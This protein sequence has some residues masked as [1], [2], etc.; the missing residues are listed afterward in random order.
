[1]NPP[2]PFSTV[3]GDFPAHHEPDLEPRGCR[4]CREPAEL[5]RAAPAPHPLPPAAGR[6]QPTQTPAGAAPAVCPL[7]TLLWG[8]AGRRR[9]SPVLL[10]VAGG[11]DDVGVAEVGGGS[12]VSAL[13]LLPVRRAASGVA[14]ALP[15]LL[16][17]R[18]LRTAVAGCRLVP[19][20][21]GGGGPAV[22]RPGNGTNRPLQS[23]GRPRPHR[24]AAP[25]EG[26]RETAHARPPAAT[27]APSRAPTASAARG[28][29]RGCQRRLRSAPV[30]A[31]RGASWGKGTN[32]GP[33]L[34][35]GAL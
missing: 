20:G 32:R 7:P 6:P 25:C 15:G 11:L 2:S 33:A 22:R 14:A 17:H 35:G 8:E 19:T 21:H 10:G 26:G 34:G 31:L 27:P 16:S 5:G 4:P 1:M 9:P 30:S 29:R 28:S 23:P 12:C 18:Q 24:S 13:L 3:R